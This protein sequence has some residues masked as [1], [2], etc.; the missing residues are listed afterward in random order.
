MIPMAMTPSGYAMELLALKQEIS[1][2]KTMILMAV[3][4]IKKAIASFHPPPCQPQACNMQTETEHSNANYVDSSM[5]HHDHH[6][7][8]LNLLALVQDLKYEIA[9]IVTE[10]R[11]LFKQQLLLTLHN[12]PLPHP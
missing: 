9:T 11:A 6:Q 4:E 3:D 12:R 10:S 1:Q 7:L 2:M 8:P 5:E